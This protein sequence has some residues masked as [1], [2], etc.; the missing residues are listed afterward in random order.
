MRVLFDHNV[1]HKLRAELLAFVSHEI[2]TAAHLGWT[3]LRNGEPL[4]RAEEA[5]FDAFV[6]GDGSLVDEQNL[7]LRHLVIIVLSTNNWPLLRDNR[8][9]C[10]LSMRR[11]RARFALSIVENS[12]AE[13]GQGGEIAMAPQPDR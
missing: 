3:E 5:G 9:F 13:E 10:K 4:Q 6:T 7:T 1:P 11:R 12:G 8:R 2:V